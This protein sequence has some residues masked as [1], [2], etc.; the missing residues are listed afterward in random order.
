MSARKLV[1]AID[2]P[3][4]SGKS[5]TA[6]LVAERLGYIHLDTGAMY[7]AITLKVLRAGIRPEDEEAIALLVRSTHV[8][9]RQAG[10]AA[11]VLLDGEDV[12]ANIRTP[13]VTRAVSAVSSQRAVRSVMVREQRR[14]GE[15]GGIVLEGRDIGT[16]VFP[17]A[18]VKFFLIAGIEARARRRAEELRVSGREADAALLAQEIR[19]RDALDSSRQ[20]SPLKRAADAIE[21]DTSDLTIDEQVRIVLDAVRRKMEEAGSK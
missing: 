4:A 18:D 15:R 8:E 19:E 17:D 11:H 13:E 12:S 6:K 20:E 7:R 3:A 14:M 21:V 2:G 5:T 10:A 16:V 9:L 1:I